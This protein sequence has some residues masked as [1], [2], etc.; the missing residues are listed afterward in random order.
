[1]VG[2]TTPWKSARTE[3]FYFLESQHTIVRK[4]A[5][6]SREKEKKKSIYLWPA[7]FPFLL[8]HFLS[9]SAV[10]GILSK[11]TAQEMLEPH[12]HEKKKIRS[13]F[14]RPRTRAW[15]RQSLSQV[16]LFTTAWTVVCQAPLSMGILQARIQE[17]VAIFLLQGIFPIQG[18]NPRLLMSHALAGGLFT[19]WVIR[20]QSI[21]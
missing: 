14:G 3:A 4:S 10:E 17:W 13:V 5:S 18:S 12:H 9:G 6:N 1:M 15:V 2:I 19:H 20:K 8:G 21:I 11:L 7:V 16:W